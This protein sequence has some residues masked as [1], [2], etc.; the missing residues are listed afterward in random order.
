MPVQTLCCARWISQI[1][2]KI[3]IMKLPLIQ[4]FLA[5]FTFAAI[6]ADTNAPAIIPIP[7][8]MTV[9]EGV[10]TLQPQTKIQ[11]DSPS[12]VTGEFLATRTAHRDGLSGQ[13]FHGAKGAGIRNILLTTKGCGPG[14]W[15]TR[16]V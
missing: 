2:I 7:Q 1:K 3:W 11:V 13:G 8:Q 4:L 10:F 6:G 14:P 15:A 5:C 9:Q 12:K 16:G